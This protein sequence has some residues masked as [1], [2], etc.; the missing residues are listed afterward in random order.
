LRAR[1]QNPLDVG[2]TGP[3]IAI[4]NGAARGRLIAE[5]SAPGGIVIAA[6]GGRTMHRAITGIRAS[7]GHMSKS[8]RSP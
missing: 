8:N 2:R 3:G 1:T 5:K 7:D 6:R 4:E